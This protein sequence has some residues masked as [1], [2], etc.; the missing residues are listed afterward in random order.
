MSKNPVL[1]SGLSMEELIRQQKEMLAEAKARRAALAA[2]GAG[3]SGAGG[4]GTAPTSHAGD[5]A[6]Q[7]TER[8]GASESTA[9]GGG[10]EKANGMSEGEGPKECVKEGKEGSAQTAGTKRKAVGADEGGVGGS[11]EAKSKGRPK[12]R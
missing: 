3:K 7:A 10:R 12:K 9:D 6:M 4:A 1:A 8:G 5:G 11:P 2:K